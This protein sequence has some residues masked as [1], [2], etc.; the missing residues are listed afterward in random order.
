[1]DNFYASF[2]QLGLLIVGVVLDD[3]VGH[4]GGLKRR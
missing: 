2:I 1:M 3:L 4:A